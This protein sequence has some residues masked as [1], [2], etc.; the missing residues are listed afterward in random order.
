MDDS[1]FWGILLLVAAMK[2][3]RVTRSTTSSAKVSEASAKEDAEEG[4][5]TVASLKEKLA[6]MRENFVNEI[7]ARKYAFYHLCDKFKTGKRHLTDEMDNLGTLLSGFSTHLQYLRSNV[8]ELF[9]LVE[10][11]KDYAIRVDLMYEHEIDPEDFIDHFDEFVP[12]SEKLRAAA[13]DPNSSLSI[14]RLSAS[15]AQT[16]AAAADEVD[17]PSYRLAVPSNR[18]VDERVER[19]PTDDD[20]N[21]PSTHDQ[22]SIHHANRPKHVCRVVPSR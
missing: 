12:E 6:T 3:T 10:R 14:A 17:P 13:E 20:I 2:K 7:G 15:R 1:F 16:A 19:L 5:E 18:F 9:D 22:P 4:V 11:A 21:Q 8:E